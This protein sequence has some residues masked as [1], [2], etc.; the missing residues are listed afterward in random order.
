MTEKYLLEDDERIAVSDLLE[1]DLNGD[2]ISIK[3]KPYFI[4]EKTWPDAALGKLPESNRP[5]LKT[6]KNTEIQKEII[7]QRDTSIKMI[8]SRLIIL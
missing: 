6:K 5:Q 2:D 1:V 7:K 4:R 3:L 8:E